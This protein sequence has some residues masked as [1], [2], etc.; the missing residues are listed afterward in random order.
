MDKNKLETPIS[1]IPKST[2]FEKKEPEYEVGNSFYKLSPDV[3]LGPITPENLVKLKDELSVFPMAFECFTSDMSIPQTFDEF[4]RAVNW[5]FSSVKDEK[6]HVFS[7]HLKKVKPVDGLE[8]FTK[9]S[10]NKTGIMADDLMFDYFVD[11][12]YMSANN[13]WINIINN[14]DLSKIILSP[15][16]RED[17]LTS[18]ILH[19]NV[20]TIMLKITFKFI[21]KKIDESKKSTKAPLKFEYQNDFDTNG[22]LYWIG[23]NG[24]RDNIWTNPVESGKIKLEIS[25]DKMYNSVDMKKSSIITR[26]VIEPTYWGGS[27]PQW[28]TI[29]LGPDYHICVDKFTLRHGHSAPNSYICDFEFL[30]SFDGKN[31][32]LLYSQYDPPF[33]TAF[34][35]KTFTIKSCNQFYRYFK[36]L[37]KGNYS[38]GTFGGTSGGAP[39]LCINGFEL[40]GEVLSDSNHVSKIALSDVSMSVVSILPSKRKTKSMTFEYVSDFDKNGILYYLATE[41]GKK[42][43]KNP[44]TSGV[45]KLEISHKSL[46]SSDMVKDNIIDHFKATS[47]YW[48]GSCPQWFS[49][50]LGEKNLVK[51]TAYTL[52]HGF[53]SYNSYIC[54]WE[55]QGSTDNKK[56]DVLHSE[57]NPPFTKGYDTKT[58]KLPPQT[59]FYRYFRVLQKGNYSMGLGQSGG[60]PYLCISGFEIYG[61]KFTGVEQTEPI[62]IDY[63]RVERLRKQ[64][65]NFTLDK[66]YHVQLLEKLNDSTIPLNLRELCLDLV[67]DICASTNT[68]IQYMIEKLD[69]PSFIISAVAAPSNITEKSFQLLSVFCRN[70]LFKHQLY[71]VILKLSPDLLDKFGSVESL[72]RFSSCIGSLWHCDPVLSEKSY[73]NLLIE[74]GQRI[75]K[76]K[77]SLYNILAKYNLYDFVLESGR[78]TPPKPKKKDSSKKKEEVKTVQ[79]AESMLLAALTDY[80]KKKRQLVTHL[81]TEE[82]VSKSFVTSLY[83]ECK[84]AQDHIYSCKKKLRKLQPYHHMVLD[85]SDCTMDRLTSIAQVL[86]N[87]LIASTSLGE[88]KVSYPSIVLEKIFD[89]I[90]VNGT[91]TT[92]ELGTK[93]L[94]HIFTQQLTFPIQAHLR[95]FS[96]SSDDGSDLRE[97]AFSSLKPLMEQDKNRLYYINELCLIIDKELTESQIKGTPLDTKLIT[98]TLRMLS[99]ISKGVNEPAHPDSKC[100]GCGMA[101]IRGVRYRCVNCVDYDI[102]A[103]CEESDKAQHD[104][105]H[106]FVKI[107]N[108]LPLNP[109]NK[110]D[111]SKEPLLPVLPTDNFGIS[112]IHNI[113]C[114]G[115]G[116]KKIEGNRYLCLQCDEYNLCESCEKKVEHYK[117]HLFLKVKFPL[118][119]L[120]EN[121]NPKALVPVL[122]HHA[123]YPT[124][125]ES[126][127]E[128]KIEEVSEPISLSQSAMIRRPTKGKSTISTES[129]THI[130]HLKTAFR[131]LSLSISTSPVSHP[132]FFLSN[133]VL[134]IFA[135]QYTP[136]EI[137][138]DIIL[139]KNFDD[140]LKNMEKC[141]SLFRS[142]MIQ[143]FITLL[144][145]KET[146]LREN[147]SPLLEQEFTSVLHQARTVLLEKILKFLQSSRSRMI[148]PFYLELLFILALNTKPSKNKEDAPQVPKE[149]PEK[150]NTS[151]KTSSAPVFVKPKQKAISSEYPLDSI[152]KVL[153]GNL[154][155]FGQPHTSSACRRWCD[156][157]RLFQFTNISSL[158]QHD[159]IY[160][161]YKIALR[162]SRETQDLITKD[163]SSLTEIIFKSKNIK[164]DELADFYSKLFDIIVESLVSSFQEGN[165]Q[166]FFN[167]VSIMKKNF[168]GDMVKHLRMESIAQLAHNL[169]VYILS[170]IKKGIFDYQ[171]KYSPIS[172]LEFCEQII[173]SPQFTVEMKSSFLSLTSK[174]SQDK[175]FLDYVIDIFSYVTVSLETLLKAY[176]KSDLN[177]VSLSLYTIV[178]VLGKIETGSQ[179]IIKLCS[180]AIKL[181]RSSEIT[182]ELL[183]NHLRN[184][185]LLNYFFKDLN[186]HELLLSRLNSLN[187]SESFETLG[188]TDSSVSQSLENFSPIGKV[189]EPKSDYFFPSLLKSGVLYT[190]YLAR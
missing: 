10:R 167:L 37:Q 120:S 20:N 111:L 146:Y 36:I 58:F 75:L 140:F 158:L 103:S 128:I 133:D 115:C 65:I 99:N 69:L 117:H 180:E 47:T 43:Y 163:I 14:F 62:I 72:N 7:L 186:G 144:C 46:Y 141:N 84:D 78:F 86:L 22:L 170:E 67:I 59:K 184:E 112:Q 143:T 147:I 87:Q 85:S 27:C 55:F 33:T 127:T 88:E 135:K 39:Y 116:S 109:S 182:T 162:G 93:F 2:T 70:D 80:E 95:Y 13:D 175:P 174:L 49:V 169:A 98:W 26:D 149:E 96:K 183:V 83:H 108:P 157:L 176:K 179:Q 126:T 132:L 66:T 160:T 53:S 119:Q 101:P 41:G 23:T 104:K 50:D 6:T 5:K 74:T 31:W 171:P 35:T 54:D 155:L 71:S 154:A 105:K 123:F 77:S 15:Q 1:M 94:K 48:G 73:V 152:T 11:V 187:I 51:C 29:D 40:Y 102:C 81:G 19:F 68:D 190:N 45:V 137:L 136:A 34:G 107:P 173:T 113:S 178:E 18:G 91:P 21:P 3:D 189:L 129:V 82:K 177:I 148:A 150:P 52:R 172:T 8:I 60:S 156:T 151:W 32:D 38:M 28:F 181:E 114:D 145:K 110:K 130:N 92:R 44:A 166:L 168:N 76:H 12:D 25:H 188:L 185:K 89:L 97:Y 139:H 164:S 57:I 125:S 30:G 165:T 63:E 4:T 9:L 106:L 138:N 56:W 134:N 118:A 16:Q 100:Q 121:E 90:C 124:K 24:K 131:I 161:I 153:I 42:P 17:G 159:D 142:T 64:L 122:L 61:E 79:V